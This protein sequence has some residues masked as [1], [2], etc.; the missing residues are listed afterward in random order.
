MSHAVVKPIQQNLH[1]VEI[2]R[3]SH[4]DSCDK[5]CAH[6]DYHFHIL[7][8]CRLPYCNRYREGKLET[9]ACSV[10]I[11]LV[12]HRGK[13]RRCAHCGSST[14]KHY[15]VAWAPVGKKYLIDQSWAACNDHCALE[16]VRRAAR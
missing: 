16:L 10:E 2:K 5:R 11:E 4:A 1:V 9:V 15:R 13:K 3:C 14:D 12:A 7:A 8:G 6:R